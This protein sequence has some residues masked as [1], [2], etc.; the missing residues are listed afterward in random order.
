MRIKLALAGLMALLVFI[1]AGANAYPA[2][3]Q[4]TRQ[5]DTAVTFVGTLDDDPDVFV[6]VAVLGDEATIYICDGQA[7]KN[8]VSV[9]EWF[10]GPM[11]RGQ[12]EVLNESGNRVEVTLSGDIGSGQFTFADG[13]VKTFTLIRLEAGGLFRSEFKF[14]ENIFVGGWIIF[15]D[16]SARGAVLQRATANTPAILQPASFVQFNSITIKI[17]E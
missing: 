8:T 6:A 16:G 7:D 2:N 13:T 12:V 9:A 10:I 11:L 5:D 14:G 3:A 4:P 1:G 15:A 17:T